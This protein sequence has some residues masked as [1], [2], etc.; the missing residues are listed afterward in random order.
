MQRHLAMKLINNT[1]LK[2]CVIAAFSF[3]L[4]TE[5]ASAARTC[6]PRA[7]V[8]GGDILIDDVQRCPSNYHDM[9]VSRG[10]G[11]GSTGNSNLFD[12]FKTVK[13]LQDAEKQLQYERSVAERERQLN[14]TSERR[15]IQC[16]EEKAIRAVSFLS[17]TD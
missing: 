9:G 12:N 16:C 17:E 11:G 7:G 15:R 3:L 10:A 1:L 2:T 13:D 6:S 14:Q 5:P 8:G 4:L